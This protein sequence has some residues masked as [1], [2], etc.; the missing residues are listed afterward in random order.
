MSTSERHLLLVG[1]SEHGRGQLPGWRIVASTGIDFSLP[2]PDAVL[3]SDFIA[4]EQWAA[5]VEQ[6]WP[7]ALR[8]L[9]GD[10][11]QSL[12]AARAQL[13]QRRLVT[14]LDSNDFRELFATPGPELY[15]MMANTPL[16]QREIAAVLRCDLNLLASDAEINLLINGF[17][18]PEHIL[19][20]SPPNGPAAVAAPRSFAQRSGFV[21][22]ADL[23]QPA[24]WDTLMWSRRSLW[25]MI[26][27]R[28]PDAQL[29]IYSRDLPEKARALHD[30]AEGFHV[31][32]QS[33][34]TLQLLGNA[35]VCLAPLRMGCGIKRGLLEAMQA[36]TPSVTTPM[37][38]EAMH[39]ALPW[40]GAVVALAESLADAAAQLHDDEP[41]WHQAQQQAHQLLD[42][43]Y[44]GRVHAGALAV[45]IEQTLA[46]L[47]QHRLYNFAGAMLRQ[48]RR[49]K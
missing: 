12:A 35:R 34:D 37:G 40:P 30:P 39:G 24:H 2:A 49:S 41:R 42:Q 13:L 19:H 25:P 1:A 16:A 29:H 15:R 31:L 17:G 5:A 48:Q 3:F 20:W 7:K 45:R 27:R 11:L 21:S 10:G 38:S 26:R 9:Y 32:A 46:D 8:I 14:G 6:H 44:D 47:A 22:V 4:E 43:R 33:E 18:V 23:N 28:L 36:G